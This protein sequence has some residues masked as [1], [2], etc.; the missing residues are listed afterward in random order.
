MPE[1]VHLLVGEPQ[2]SSLAIVI[3]V[4][5]QRTSKILKASDEKQFWQRRYYDF[6]VRNPEKAALHAPES[7]KA[8]IS[9][10][11]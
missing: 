3:Q 11:P 8:R 9:S 6:N 5:K 1:H 4:L 7:R 2:I 10:Q